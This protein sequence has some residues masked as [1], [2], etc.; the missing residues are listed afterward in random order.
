MAKV[1]VK[2]DGAGFVMAVN[3]DVFLADIKGWLLVDEG[4]GERYVYAQ[5]QYLDGPL[6]DELGV[7]LYR[8]QTGGAF[9]HEVVLRPADE[10]ETERQAIMEQARR[11]EQ[12]KTEQLAQQEAAVR[13]AALTAQTLPDEQ[14]ASVKALY[15]VY[16]DAGVKYEEGDRR[17]W[18]TTEDAPEGPG[19]EAL[20]KCKQGHTSQWNWNPD[21]APTMW[22]R[23]DEA[24]SGDSPQ[25]AIPAQLYMRY[26]EDKYYVEAGVVYKCTRDYDGSTG[27]LPSQLVGQFFE[28][29]EG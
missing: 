13:V 23:I 27:H 15:E 1:Y 29:W 26:V 25:D 4:E 16:S 21:R 9:G 8:V 19:I 11:D 17:R 18:T 12:L 24:H 10:V 6:A 20:V 5:S 7:L 2:D 14:A 3:S 28:V 22:E